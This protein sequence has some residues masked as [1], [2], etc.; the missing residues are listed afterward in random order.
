MITLIITMTG[1]EMSNIMICSECQSRKKDA[2][3][4]RKK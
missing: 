3:N 2:K 4:Q 1:R